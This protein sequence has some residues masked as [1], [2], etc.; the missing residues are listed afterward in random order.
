[1]NKLKKIVVQAMKKSAKGIY[2]LSAKNA[3]E[4][5][6][7]FTDY[8][9]DNILWFTLSST[10][11]SYNKKPYEWDVIFDPN[12]ELLSNKK[13]TITEKNNDYEI[14][15]YS[16]KSSGSML[17]V[18]FHDI[19][20]PI[21]NKVVKYV[22]RELPE[23]IEQKENTSKMAKIISKEILKSA[24][25]SKKAFYEDEKAALTKYL[26]IN[27][28]D[29]TKNE[30]SFHFGIPEFTTK[31]GEQY[32]VSASESAIKDAVAENMENL[33]DE[34]GFEEFKEKVLPYVG[35]FENTFSVSENH[36][37]DEVYRELEE[38]GIEEPTD[39]QIEKRQQEIIDNYGSAEEF[40][41]EFGDE[42]VKQMI[43]HGDAYM[44]FETMAENVISEYG[45][46]HELASYDNDTNEI[47]Y[48]GKT[49]YIFRQQ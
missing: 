28:K 38:D 8:L 16:D 15:Y 20:L 33:F 13:F 24:K 44:N 32:S 49:Y 46:G 4:N 19:N 45:A 9:R 39:E 2:D 30:D 25:V 22:N 12:A 5:E 43:D 37:Y 48:N 14:N 3:M 7:F 36:F 21:L 17:K 18:T 47:E 29:I 27:E 34:L 40:F 35:G 42:Y 26:N 10:S 41:I 23:L 1:M 11:S 31:S 6:N